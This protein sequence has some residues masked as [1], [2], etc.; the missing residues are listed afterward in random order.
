M[1]NTK[2]EF[3]LP[4]FKYET[5]NVDGIVTMKAQDSKEAFSDTL[6]EGISKSTAKAVY[7]HTQAYLKACTEQATEVAKK[8]IG[9]KD[10]KK[11]IVQQN[12]GPTGSGTH[13]TAILKD[14]AFRNVATGA[15][16]VK[17]QHIAVTTKHTDL[18]VG[19]SFIRS[20]EAKAAGKI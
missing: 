8:E 17:P 5:T 7:S 11:V 15:E 9:K 18:S 10:V 4:E 13:T 2:E 6:P 14:K 16:I 1:A 19:K 3:E 20:L 12:F